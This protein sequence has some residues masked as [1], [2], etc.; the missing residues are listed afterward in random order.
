MNILFNN[1]IVEFEEAKSLNDLVFKMVKV[2]LFAV[3]VNGKFVP[4][5]QYIN[6]PVNPNDKIDIVIPMQGG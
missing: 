3:S 2:S 5:S 1:Q 4:K 6:T